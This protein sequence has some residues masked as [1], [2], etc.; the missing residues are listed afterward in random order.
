MQEWRDEGS[1]A[2]SVLTKHKLSKELTIETLLISQSDAIAEAAE[3]LPFYNT[4]RDVVRIGLASNEA[5]ALSLNKT[6]T[7]KMD[8]LGY[9]SGKP[10]VV[11]GRDD[12]YENEKTTLTLWG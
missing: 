3:L 7:L 9:S 10:M 6:V 11:I 1:E 2:P 8:G 12:D 5:D 4:N